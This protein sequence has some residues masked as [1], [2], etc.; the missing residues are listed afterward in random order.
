MTDLI[1]DIWKGLREAGMAEVMLYLP[2]GSASRCHWDSTALIGETRVALLGDQDRNIVR[3]IPIAS[4]IGIGI[5][6]PKG[7]DPLG[8]RAVVLSKL[9]EVFP[10][11]DT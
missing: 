3:I 8:Y 6:S 1:S 2:D 4:C 9:H 5:P 7:I 10:G 11:T